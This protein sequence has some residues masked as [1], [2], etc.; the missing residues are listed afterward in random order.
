MLGRHTNV[1]AVLSGHL[2]RPIHRRFAGTVASTCPSTAVQL[3]FTL[4][5]EQPHYTNEPG[6]I[7]VHVF[8]AGALNSHL[9]PIVTA[10]R[11]VPSWADDEPDSASV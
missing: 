10:D 4:R 7:A 3:G 5:D 1:E 2:H 6:A 11:W 8:E 9:V